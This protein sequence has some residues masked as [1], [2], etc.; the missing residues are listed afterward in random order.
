M[1]DSKGTAKLPNQMNLY[2]RIMVAAYFIYLGFSFGDV[3]NR[4]VG[5]ELIFYLLFMIGFVIIGLI[6]SVLSVKDLVT[7]RYVGGKLDSDKEEMAENKG[8]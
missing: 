1:N 8:K 4:Y 7:G 6:I 5:A 3:W 2:I